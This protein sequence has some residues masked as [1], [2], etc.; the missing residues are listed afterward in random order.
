MRYEAQE[1]MI[2]AGLK[3]PGFRNLM[4]DIYKTYARMQ[5]YDMSRGGEPGF[6]KETRAAR[7][8]A[9]TVAFGLSRF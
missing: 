6:E 7:R 8:I 4:M 9:G 1:A 5:R 2:Q 3:D